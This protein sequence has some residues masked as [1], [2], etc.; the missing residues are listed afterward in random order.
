M[1]HKTVDAV[2]IAV[3]TI[4]GKKSSPWRF[5]GNKKGDIYASAR[6]MGNIFKISLHYDGNC[7]A[8]FTSEFK[9]KNT[10]LLQNRSRHFDRWDISLNSTAVA[11]QVLFPESELRTF[12]PKNL[13]KVDW[14]APPIK[15]Q[16]FVTTIYSLPIS[17]KKATFDL[18]ERIFPIASFETSHRNAIIVGHYQE[19]DLATSSWIEDEKIRF[20]KHCNIPKSEGY[21]AIV[22]GYD[23]KNNRRWFLDMAWQ[24]Q[25]K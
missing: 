10:G 4:E 20:N 9:A 17:T 16:M 18:V 8:G 11:M 19:L 23:N 14:L 12:R 6:S 24:D 3:G 5:W 25:D 1:E 21:R 15:N 2:R 22:G 7:F 13:G